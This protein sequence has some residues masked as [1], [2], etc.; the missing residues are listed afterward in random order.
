M[1]RWKELTDLRQ[2]KDTVLILQTRC[3]IPRLF[4]PLSYSH[5]LLYM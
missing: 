4:I 1:D 3:T 2:G 5:V